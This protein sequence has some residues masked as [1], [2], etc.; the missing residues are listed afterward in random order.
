MPDPLLED[1]S[2]PADRAVLERRLEELDIRTTTVRHPPVFTVEE[3]KALRGDL[4][5]CHT[6]NLFVRD[7]KG[8]MWLVVCR[9][10]RRVD[11]AAL[12]QELGCGRLSFGSPDRLMRYLGVIPGAVTPF[13]V[14]NDRSGRVGV[15]MDRGMVAH[16]PWNFHPLD[17]AMTTAIEPADMVRFLEAQ[18]HAPLWIGFP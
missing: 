1:G 2:V 8:V 17:N 4:P 12:A 13:A 14:I 16:A 9:E 6:K 10:D 5:G 11:L 7:R 3:A 15:A 18:G